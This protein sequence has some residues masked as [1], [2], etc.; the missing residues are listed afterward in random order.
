[1][2]RRA[3]RVSCFA[4]ITLVSLTAGAARADHPPDPFAGE[5]RLPRAREV[6]TTAGQ[7]RMIGSGVLA[8]GG[9]APELGLHGTLEL[10]TFAYLGVRGSL[11]TTV[12]HADDEPLVAAARVGPSLHL[13]PYRRVDVSL[14]FEGGAALVKP[15]STHLTAMPVLAPGLT[16][17]VWLASWA[18]IRLEGH[19]EW[20]LY[21]AP[22]E[23]SRYLRYVGLM[24][25]GFAL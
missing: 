14:F 15:R 7:F 8:L 16:L 1:V 20:G 21:E 6:G 17:E 19:L 13:L 12:L 23:A 25:L 22:P 3:V 24:G 11:Q 10:M 18:L 5:Y 9:S 4:A 2:Y